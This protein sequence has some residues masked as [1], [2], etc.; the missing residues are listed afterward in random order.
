MDKQRKRL[1]QHV[2]TID[3][4]VKSNESRMAS[5]ADANSEEYVGIP[6]PSIPRGKKKFK[7][8]G[9]KPRS[10]GRIIHESVLDK[11]SKGRG[12]MARQSPMTITLRKVFNMVRKN[13]SYVEKRALINEVQTSAVVRN[14]LQSCLSLH[15]LLKTL[16]MM[17][18]QLQQ[19]RQ[20]FPS[21]CLQ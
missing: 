4:Y 8:R 6:K 14:A 7:G 19:S 12:K 21:V 13:K 2:P 1:R 17:R 10:N 16:L 15:L 5:R 3:I 11:G 9:P 18:Y 20:R